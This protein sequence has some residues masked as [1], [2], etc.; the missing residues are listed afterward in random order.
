MKTRENQT[1]KSRERERERGRGGGGGQRERERERERERAL[2]PV[3]VWLVFYF[4]AKRQ[5]GNEIL[6]RFKHE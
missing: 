2:M 6:D 3:T 1:T 4:M 5:T